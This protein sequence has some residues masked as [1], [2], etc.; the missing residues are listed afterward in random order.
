MRRNQRNDHYTRPLHGY[1]TEPLPPPSTAQQVLWFLKRVKLSAGRFFRSKIKQPLTALLGVSLGFGGIYLGF[2]LQSDGPVRQETMAMLKKYRLDTPVSGIQSLGAQLTRSAE[3][4][5][6]VDNMKRT[7]KMAE[8]F[9]VEGG[10]YAENVEQLYRQATLNGFWALN[11]NPLTKSRRRE[12]IIAD[13]SAYNF[14]A[15]KKDFAGMVLYE[16]MG[17]YDYRIY[18]CD[19]EGQLLTEKNKVVYLS[20]P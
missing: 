2:N 6:L 9:P 19:E 15:E 8:A 11:R 16:P 7:R 20:K 13:Y 12:G 17:T 10:P 1:Q 4:T 5:V 3:Y 18:A 14:A